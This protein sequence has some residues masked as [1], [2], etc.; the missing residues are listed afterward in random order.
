MMRRMAVVG[1]KL[2]NGGEVSYCKGPFFTL[3]NAGQ[4][5]ALINGPVY[6]PVCRTTGYIARDGGPRRMTIG[7]SEIALDADVVVCDCPEYPRIVAR[8]AGEAWY[9]DLAE[10][11]GVI[12]ATTI[13]EVSAQSATRQREQTGQCVAWF[14]MRDSATG[15]PLRDQDVIAVVSGVHRSCR[16]DANGYAKVETEGTQLI[17]IHTV[18]S[19]PKRNLIPVNGD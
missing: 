15:L 12:G 3:G 6:C 17:E 4:Q 18:F 13:A 16:T 7:G 1:D 8:L 9:D 2:S 19:S 11:L 14:C 10:K 5:A